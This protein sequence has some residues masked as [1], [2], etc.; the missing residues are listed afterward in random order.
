[1]SALTDVVTDSDVE[2]G[3]VSSALEAI[4]I[5]ELPPDQ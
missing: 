2:F 4:V 5:Q 3:V 1:M